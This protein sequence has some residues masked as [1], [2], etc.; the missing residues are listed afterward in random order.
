[1]THTYSDLAGRAGRAA[2]MLVSLGLERGGTVSVLA[3]NSLAALEA[4]FAVPWAGGVLNALNTRLSAA[5]LEY[6][7]GHAETKV[8]IVDEWLLG[9]A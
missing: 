8:L 7:L 6:I 5:E 4:H 2:G 3:P 1:M 9:V